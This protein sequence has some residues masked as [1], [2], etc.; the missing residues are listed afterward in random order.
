[1]EVMAMRLFKARLWPFWEIAML[2][3]Y[4]VIVGMIIGVYIASAVKG[5]LWI[6]I[7]VAVI[8]AIRLCYFYFLKRD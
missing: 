5:Y 3:L 1:M 8:L 6:F 2:K 7:L 4:C